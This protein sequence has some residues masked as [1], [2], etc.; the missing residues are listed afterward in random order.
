MSETDAERGQWARLERSSPTLFLAAGALLLV[1]GSLN[2][3]EAFVDAGY[4][5]VSDVIIGPAGFFL[6]FVALWGLY[7]TV[8]DRSPKLAKV[9]TVFAGIG[10]IG[11]LLAG[12]RRLVE[13]TG[14]SSAGW[15][16]AV[17]LL[18]PVGF[19]LGFLTFSVGSFRSDVLS[20]TVTIALLLPLFGVLL[21]FAVRAAGIPIPVGRVMINLWF[22][23]AHLMIGATLRTRLTPARRLEASPA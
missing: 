21:N 4:P 7:P 3:M 15:L 13:H 2:G 23:V 5:F 1:Y 8:A 12:V 11:W 18:I 16:E 20:R 19:A 9:A 14:G 22:A 6:G 17:G 10:A